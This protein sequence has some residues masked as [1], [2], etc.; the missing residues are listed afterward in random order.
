MSARGFIGA[1]DLYIARQIG[2]V[3]ESY[4][5]PFEC[6]KFEIKPN[7][8]LKEQV[9]KGRSSY[10]QVIETVAIPKPSDLSIELAEVNKTTLALA[11]LGTAAALTQVSGT[12][13][14]EAIVASLDGW[15]PL[16]K[17]AL[18]GAQTVTGASGAV[19][20]GSIAGTTLTVTAVASGTLTAGQVLSGAG[21]TVGTQI[22][23]LLSGTGGVGTYTVSVS[24]TVASTSITA[25]AAVYVNG[26]D[27]I[28]NPQLGW[29]KALVGGKIADLQPLLI[30][31]TYAA[32]TGTAIA[33]STAT[34]IRAKFKLDGKNFADD[35]PVICTVHEGVVAASAAFDFLAAD[36]NSVSL[37]G[38]MKTPA[39]FTEPFNVHLRDA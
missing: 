30:G 3:Y 34:Q 7:V 1:G 9:S 11:L 8:D 38:R 31:S 14:A 39:G 28:I 17:A 27:Y 25:T 10:G 22:T 29:V 2:G 19:V 36:F 6:K 26:V 20:T 18:T 4:K 23:A 35:L 5:G 21:V 16:S 12:L 24:Q 15:V 13:V 37:P 33:G 32:I